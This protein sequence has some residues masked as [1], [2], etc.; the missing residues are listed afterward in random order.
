MGMTTI[1]NGRSSADNLREID[2]VSQ[3]VKKELDKLNISVG[4]NFYEK[5]GDSV[6]YN[7]TLV[8]S[9]LES[10]KGKSY[11]EMTKSNSAV[12]VMAVQIALESKGYDCGKIDGIL[13][14]KTKA[15]I[16]KFQEKNWFTW[17]DI[18][19]IPGP[20]TINKLLEVLWWKSGWVE[21][22]KEKTDK[23]KIDKVKWKDKKQVKKWSEVDPKDLVDNLPDWW[24]VEVEG[25]GIDTSK[26]GEVQVTLIVKVGEETRT[27]N[28]IV[29][30]VV[31]ITEENKN[32]DR[33][34]NGDKEKK[35]GDNPGDKDEVDDG[36]EEHRDLTYWKEM[37]AVVDNLPNGSQLIIK[38]REELK[39]FGPNLYD[40]YDDNYF[41]QYSLAL[42]Y[43]RGTS[44][45]DKGLDITSVNRIPW[46][47]FGVNVKY[48]D[49][50]IPGSYGGMMMSPI[51]ECLFVEINKNEE[52]NV[53]WEC[54]NPWPY[55]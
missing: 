52:N 25:N 32:D 45:A 38:D 51:A 18:D 29:V 14:K 54:E 1:E 12:M 17:K 55:K 5:K 10:I 7:M 8:I 35:K 6:E 16:K 36:V 31:E 24:T 48:K 53:K 20:K 23:E 11:V 43:H 42:Y 19:G 47:L 34:D 15:A 27:I 44:T 39:K 46:P 41:K 13:W 37:C 3:Q 33:N 30:V 4:D 21:G 2:W 40:K 49:L 22:D 28:V 9:Y 26:T 50:S